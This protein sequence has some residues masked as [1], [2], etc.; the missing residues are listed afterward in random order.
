[1]EKKGNFAKK[2]FGV[3][4]SSTMNTINTL[5]CSNRSVASRLNQVVLLLFGTNKVISGHMDRVSKASKGLSMWSGLE[6]KTRENRMRNLTSACLDKGT[7]E[8]FTAVFSYLMGEY[9]GDAA[10]VFLEVNREVTKGSRHKLEHAS[11]H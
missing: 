9:R 1:M 7:L 8:L 3:L 11:S 10:T 6:H 2:D 5:V 4:V